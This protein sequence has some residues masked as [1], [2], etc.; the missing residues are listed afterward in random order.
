MSRTLLPLVA[1]LLVSCSSGPSIQ[2]YF[3]SKTED[4]SFLIVDIPTSIF[5]IDK[6]TLTVEEQEVFSSFKKLNLLLFRKTDSNALLMQDELK[7]IRSIVDSNSFE[8]LMVFSD[9]SYSGKLLMQGP[10]DRP[11]E[12]LLFA[13]S[14]EGFLVTRLIGHKMQVDKALLLANIIQREKGVD[15]LERVF[16]EIF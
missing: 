10:D 2:E 11:N 1:F 15:Q 13:S 6:S 8:S 9:K 12:I 16:S 14:E 4:P 7:T 5:G 3:V